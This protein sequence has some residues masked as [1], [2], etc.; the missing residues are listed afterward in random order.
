L[1]V[2][3]AGRVELDEFHVR[4]PAAGS[5]SHGDAVAGGSVRI[6]R[7]EVDLAGAA[8]RQN[9][10]IGGEGEDFVVGDIE[11]V[12][13]ETAFFGLANLWAGD[14]V[15]RNV[16]FEDRD[17]GVS[18][19]LLGQRSLDGG[20]GSVGGVDDASVAVAAFASQVIANG[21]AGVAGERYTM[22]DKPMNGARC[23][24]DNKAGGFVGAQPRPRRV[25]ICDMGF[26]AVGRIENRGDSTLGPGAGTVFQCSFSYDSNFEF[27]GEA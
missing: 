11:H 15:Y 9:R 19:E 16:M 4:Y 27:V 1:R 6:G 21:G 24:L 18:P 3:Q 8:R 13:A 7:V 5:P 17:A 26:S 20:A 14:Q 25:C 12:G 22:I 10:M 2:I 23:V